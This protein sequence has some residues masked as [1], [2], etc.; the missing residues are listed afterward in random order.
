VPVTLYYAI[1]LSMSQAVSL[2]VAFLAWRRRSVTGSL[3]LALMM[4]AVAVWSAAAAIEAVSAD[5]STK[6][7]WSQMSYVGIAAVPT[8][9]LLFA[10]KYWRPAMKIRRLY[11]VLLWIIPLC[12]IV[13]AAT[14]G[15]HHLLWNSFTFEALDTNVMT[16][17]HGIWFWINVAYSYALMLASVVLL[18]WV[19]IGFPRLYRRQA[20][21]VLIAAILPW[22]GNAIY[23]FGGSPLPGL[24]IAP[25]AF[26]I[27]GL[28]LVLGILKLRLFD[29]VPVARES[30][31]QHMDIGMM[32]LDY[33]ARIV[34]LNPATERIIGKKLEVGQRIEEV[35]GG[36]QE[37]LRLPADVSER[38]EVFLEQRNPS[39]WLDVG[40]SPLRDRGKRLSGQL[41][42]LQDITER[43]LAEAALRESEARLQ[44]LFETMMEGVIL[45]APDGQIIKANPAAE[46]I[47]GLKRS[48]ITMRSYIAPEWRILRPDGTPMPAE[49]MAGPLVMKEKRP[50]KDMLMGVDHQDGTITWIN[51]SASP[52]LNDVGELEGIVGTF[53]D[54]TERKRAEEALIE[55]HNAFQHQA[56]HDPLTGVLNRRA[57]LDV[58]SRELARARRQHIGL[59][60]G[61]CDI[62][63]FKK[64]NDTYGHPVG[65]EV[66]CG[67]VRIMNSHLRQYDTLGR[68]G[69]EEFLIVTPG[70][71]ENDAIAV[72]QRLLSGVSENSLAT[73]SGNVSI[74]VSIG[75]KI[76]TGEEHVEELLKAA[77]DALYDAKNGGRNRVFLMHDKQ[78]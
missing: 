19:A 3:Y 68:F 63:H 8:L 57:I 12:T 49:E 28:I 59:T 27:T 6:I 10:L 14:N 25:I 51:V 75:V 42:T 62:D 4:L 74:T 32:V 1:A 66:L 17:G 38:K 73:K 18:S 24:D 39:L 77:D 53:A 2:A 56:T 52:I 70:V 30:M 7:I 26:S 55:A 34:D 22:I 60:I 20:V 47:L 31:I 40:I 72:Y 41:I 71:K 61:I 64:I 76:L 37:I 50:I 48:E 36:W 9:L 13:I 65:D 29:V 46:R 45:I 21:L 5:Q 33:K 58:L 43:K 23:V 16:Y 15:L 69:G 44:S 78:V 35:L 67:L 54:I 11:K